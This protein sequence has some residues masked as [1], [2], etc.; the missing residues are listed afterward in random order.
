[1]RGKLF[2]IVGSLLSLAFASAASADDD[3]E[4]K[5]A[6]FPPVPEG[7]SM[8]VDGK[9]VVYSSP[10][11]KDSKTPATQ[12]CITYTR[13]TSGKDAAAYADDYVKLNKCSQKSQHGKGFYTTNCKTVGKDAVIIG[14]SDNLYLIELKGIYNQV[15]TDLIN[16]YV[17]SVISGKHTFHDRNIGEVVTSTDKVYAPPETSEMADKSE[18]SGN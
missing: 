5:A 14:E 6:F 11:P 9:S 8:S 17:N 10:V 16:S 12:V 1:M 2:L 18:K 7:W 3:F 4:V 15:S 13:N